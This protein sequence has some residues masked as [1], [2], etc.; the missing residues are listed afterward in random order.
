MPTRTDR[1]WFGAALLIGD[2]L[3]GGGNPLLATISCTSA[4]AT[5]AS[6]RIVWNRAV[7]GFEVGD[8]TISGGS[9]ASFATADNITFTVDWTPAAGANTMDIAAGV[10][11]DAAGNA[12]LAATQYNLIALTIAPTSGDDT[13]IDALLPTANAGAYNRIYVGEANNQVGEVARTLIKFDLSSIPAGAT[14]LNSTLSLYLFAEMSSNARTLRVFRLKRAWVEGTRGFVDDNPATG[15]TWV[16]Y[17]TTN[18]WQTQGGFGADDCEQTDIGS[19]AFSA[20]EA[21]G[22]YKT[23]VL[24]ASAVQEMLTG[25]S[26]TNNGFLIK[27]DTEENDQYVFYS[28]E[29]A[30]AEKPKMN[31]MYTTNP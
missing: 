24:T 29:N 11:T 15:A 2:I 16:R 7:T 31:F 23:W 25:G 10:C 30:A 12:N 6:M 27:A 26:W 4:T 1:R 19:L 8:I 20:T 3:A 22:A 14:I 17:D 5:V 18:N 9:L 28:F 21:T 13:T